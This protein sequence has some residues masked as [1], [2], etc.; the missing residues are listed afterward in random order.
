MS[1]L[2]TSGEVNWRKYK[3]PVQ[4]S[5]IAQLKKQVKMEHLTNRIKFKLGKLFQ[6]CVVRTK[7][8]IYVFIKGLGLDLCCF[9]PLSTI[10]QLYRGYHFHW[11]R[12]QEDQENTTDLVFIKAKTLSTG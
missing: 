3:T 5:E 6:K 1:F 2:Y 10:F 12:K 8:D 4:L 7:F 9:T 11:W